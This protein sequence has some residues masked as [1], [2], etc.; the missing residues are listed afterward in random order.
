VDGIMA[1]F[2]API[3]L[4]DHAFRA[5]LAALDIHTEVTQLAVDMKRR[6]GIDLQLRIGLNSGQVIAGEIGSGTAGYTAVG[7]QVGMAQRME[8]VAPPGGVMLSE[9]TARLVE[10]A[11]IL[12]ELELVHIKGADEP[13]PARRLLAIGDHAP[14]LRGESPLVGRTWE[15]STVTAILEEAIGGRMRGQY[16]GAGGYRQEPTG[17]RS[18]GDRGWPRGARVHHLLR[19]PRQRHRVSCGGPVIALRPGGERSRRLG[20]PGSHPSSGP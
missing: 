17:A 15:I 10:D 7:E 19:V 3:A 13:V 5:C 20:G 6:D 16:R 14:N 11:A 4:E 8:S 18:R 2:G 12:T 1:L 9:S